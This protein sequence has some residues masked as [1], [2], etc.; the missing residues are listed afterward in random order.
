MN[1]PQ[2]QAVFGAMPENATRTTFEVLGT[3]LLA[4]DY[5]SLVNDLIR[6]WKQGE[7]R[8][9]SFCNTFMVTKRRTD[10]TYRETARV[11][12]TNLPD[13]MPL[14]W[15]M[16]LQ[17]ARL[18][19][20]VYGPIFMQRF[21]QA[22]PGEIR[23]YFLGGSQECLDALC[24]NARHFNTNLQLVGAHHGYFGA[25]DEARVLEEIRAHHPDFIWV[26]LGTPKQD[27]WVGLHRAAFP[28]AILLPVGS[29]FEFLAGAKPSPPLALQRLGLTWLFRLANEPRRL[30]PRYFKYNTLF[31][32][33]VVRDALLGRRRKVL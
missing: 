31:L 25:E 21:L 5:D 14:V 6:S 13:G 18:R 3:P 11:C 27:E 2:N 24:A 15:C 33:Y 1:R 29:S 17:G 12:D 22:S 7:P 16:N 28:R 26:G 30:G 4:T 9:L 20:R 8:T 19:D 23:H 32:Y 10:P